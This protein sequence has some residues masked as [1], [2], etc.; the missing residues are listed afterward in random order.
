MTAAPNAFP[1]G[2]NTFVPREPSVI[3]SGS[4]CQSQQE[5][6]TAARAWRPDGRRQASQ[7][8]GP[9]GRATT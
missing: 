9:A 6:D 2:T 4:E 1:S 5:A 3:P 8:C 7:N